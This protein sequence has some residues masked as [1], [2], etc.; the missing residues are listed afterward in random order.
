MRAIIN[1]VFASE[2]NLSAMRE[3]AAE[4][5]R[6]EKKLEKTLGDSAAIVR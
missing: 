4:D 3:G 5:K 2:W 1:Y 6:G